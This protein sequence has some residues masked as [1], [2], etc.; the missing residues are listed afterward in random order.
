MPCR[1][2][3]DHPDNDEHKTNPGGFEVAVAVETEQRIGNQDEPGY[4]GEQKQCEKVVRVTVRHET[5]IK[6][7][8]GY[9]GA[10]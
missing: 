2:K 4:R 5:S 10:A 8:T 3:P 9:H 6:Q 1:K 7:R